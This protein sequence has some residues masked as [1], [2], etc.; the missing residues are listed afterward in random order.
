MGPAKGK[1]ADP[2]ELRFR[3]SAL[4]DV[5]RRELIDA[6]ERGEGGRLALARHAGCIDGIIRDCAARACKQKPLAGGPS[7]ATDPFQSSLG[8]RSPRGVRGRRP[9]EE[10]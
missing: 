2:A 9:A 1:D 3:L 10:R 7:A 8:Y 5:A 4:L 6:T